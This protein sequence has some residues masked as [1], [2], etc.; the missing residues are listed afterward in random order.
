[1]HPGVAAKIGHFC[2]YN[3]S[4]RNFQAILKIKIAD[5]LRKLFDQSNLFFYKKHKYNFSPR[6]YL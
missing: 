3:R 5:I 2:F 1:L 6:L 4:L